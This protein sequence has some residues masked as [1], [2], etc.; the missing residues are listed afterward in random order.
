MFLDSMEYTDDQLQL[1]ERDSS[2]S[3]SATSLDKVGT[4]SETVTALLSNVSKI[5]H[6]MNFARVRLTESMLVHTK[7]VIL[8]AELL[9]R[10][11]TSIVISPMFLELKTI[12][13]A[14][15]VNINV[16][17]GQYASI[18]IS[19]MLWNSFLTLW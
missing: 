13:N 8:N 1:L 10:E 16:F 9:F 6:S 4:G 2:I 14:I 18:V 15:W 11:G 5:L 17:N 3:D 12:A 7:D 19:P